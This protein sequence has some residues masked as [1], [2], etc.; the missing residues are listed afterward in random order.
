MHADDIDVTAAG[1]HEYAVTLASRTLHVSVDP[2][3][4]EELG[5]TAVQ[6]PLL[7]R[8]AVEGLPSAE[9]AELPETIDL[10]ELGARVPGFPEVTLARLRT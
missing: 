2:G 10:R 7:L 8:R 3:L 4:L 9:L 6:E 5:L 1:E